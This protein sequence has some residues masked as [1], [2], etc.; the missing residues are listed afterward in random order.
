[1]LAGREPAG[2]APAGAWG[3]DSPHAASRASVALVEAGRGEKPWQGPSSAA[4]P[5]VRRRALLASHAWHG[6]LP[7]SGDRGT[8]VVS[9]INVMDA[10]DIRGGKHASSIDR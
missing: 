5:A 7:L 6:V 1:M 2:L 10:L 3:P 4:S 9:R 8:T